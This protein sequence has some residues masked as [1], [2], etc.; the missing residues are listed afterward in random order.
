MNILISVNANYFEAARVMLRS[1]FF[2]NK[3]SDIVI[4]LFYSDLNIQELKML[5]L[6]IEQNK[7][8]LFVKKIDD[9][10]MKNVPV[11]FLSKETYY[12]LMAPSILPQNL[13][14][15]LYLDVDMIVV[16]DIREIYEADF[17]DRLFMAVP[18]TSSGIEVVKKNLHMK[19]GSTYINAGVLLLNLELLR[20]EFNLEEALD[21]ARKYPNRVPNCDQ[22]VIN[23]LYS[24]RIGYLEWMYNY[25][26]RFH[27][28]SEILVWPFQCRKLM[29]RIKIIHYMGAGKPWRPGYN[30]KYLKEFC[31]YANHT[32]FQ[33]M[34]EKNLRDYFLN[35]IKLVKE[36]MLYK[37]KG[38]V[39]F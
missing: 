7:G 30:G 25:E 26:A 20:Q 39:A 22:D 13:E 5:R 2:H 37:L 15:I 31:R 9:D 8:T 4:Y 38:M 14:R 12:R 18:D 27:S 11:S 17:L 34:I 10:V 16:G 33:D 1:L 29:R 21:Y 3:N 28:I 23:G 6:L 19:K 32:A 36:W 35:I 24:D